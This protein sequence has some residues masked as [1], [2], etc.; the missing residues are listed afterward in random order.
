[1]KSWLLGFLAAA[2]ATGATAQDNVVNVYNWSDYIA[3]DT[4]DKFTAET[5]IAVNYDVYDNNAVVEAKLL[6]GNSGYDVVVPTANFLERQIKAGV[7]QPLDKSKIPNFSG[8]SDALLEDVAVHDPNNDHA[9]IYTWGTTGLGYNVGKVNER[10]DNAPTDSFALLFDPQYAEK[11]ADCGI[12]LIDEAPDI[13]SS[14]LAYLG[15]DPNSNDAADIDKAQEL[16]NGVRPHIR[17]FNSSQYINDLANGDVCLAFGYSGDIL[18]ARDRADEAD[19]G[20]EVAYAIPKEGAVLWFD[21]L[22]VPADAPNPDNAHAFIDFL[23]KPEI[24]AALSNYVFY[25]N[26]VPASEP[27]VSDEVKTDPG[28]YPA[29][30]VAANLFTLEAKD[31]R[32]DRRINRAFTRLKSGR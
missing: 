30:E 5:G 28:I 23:L 11:L 18:Q 2:V 10:I 9:A 21:M 27:M 4:L 1:M 25:A 6:A 12:A 31:A 22:A 8:L 7:F 15:L 29:P 16:L 19:N 14:A 3:E 17:Y 32:S 26:P 13:Y 20:V 24:M